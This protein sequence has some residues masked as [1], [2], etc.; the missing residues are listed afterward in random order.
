MVEALLQRGKPEQALWIAQTMARKNPTQAAAV[1]T[2]ARAWSAGID[3][4]GVAPAD[5]LLK[6]S[7][8]VQKA[9][10][11]EDQTLLIRVQLLAQRGDKVEAIRTIGSILARTPPPG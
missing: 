2:L 6:F 8:E 3:G 10:P 5:E 7:D 1:I 4:G 11:G 9:I